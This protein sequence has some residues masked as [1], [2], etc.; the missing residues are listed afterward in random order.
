MATYIE[1]ARDFYENHDHLLVGMD[2]HSSDELCYLLAKDLAAVCHMELGTAARRGLEE[3]I[4]P[5]VASKI[6]PT[7]LRKAFEKDTAKL[8]LARIMPPFKAFVEQLKVQAADGSLGFTATDVDLAFR[9]VT[10]RRDLPR[11]AAQRLTGVIPDL[12]DELG[13]V[14]K[15]TASVMGTEGGL[16]RTRKG[17]SVDIKEQI[18]T[19][20]HATESEVSRANEG[21]EDALRFGAAGVDLTSYVLPTDTKPNARASIAGQ[22][23]HNLLAWDDHDELARHYPRRERSVVELDEMSADIAARI[24][25]PFG[26]ISPDRRIDLV[27]AVFLVHSASSVSSVNHVVAKVEEDLHPGGRDEDLPASPY[28]VVASIWQHFGAL[29]AVKFME[30]DGGG[31]L[32]AAAGYAA[33]AEDVVETGWPSGLVGA[34]MAERGTAGAVQLLEKAFPLIESGVVASWSSNAWKPFGT[35]IA[36]WLEEEH[37]D[38]RGGGPPQSNE[39]GFTSHAEAE[40]HLKSHFAGGQFEKL[41]TDMGMKCLHDFRNHLV[42]SETGLAK[43]PFERHSVMGVNGFV[44]KFAGRSINMHLAG[45]RTQREECVR[46]IMHEQR[47][48]SGHP[49]MGFPEADPIRDSLLR[50]QLDVLEREVATIGEDFDHVTAGLSDMAVNYAGGNATTS[51]TAKVRDR[52]IPEWFRSMNTPP[53]NRRL[54]EL[55]TCENDEVFQPL[56]DAS[57]DIFRGGLSGRHLRGAA[58]RLRSFISHTARGTHPLEPSLPAQLKAYMEFSDPGVPQRELMESEAVMLGV[59]V[60]LDA[61]LPATDSEL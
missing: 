1:I 26:L 40:A 23:I 11:T 29:G 44:L 57:Q 53:V 35:V 41:R 8:R 4:A 49:M 14:V 59:C 61:H 54:I 22:K 43:I 32:R 27:T 30:V 51:A 20:R 18:E 12:V 39:D 3:Q 25:F 6:S 56:S 33:M 19:A 47:L 37:S 15:V 2:D 50:L 10:R 46:D 52:I 42:N 38:K 58:M 34:V 13:A 48:A 9:S 31:L 17:L 60:L 55:S 45:L 28:R 7:L 16:E 24:N 36:G 21:L 5:E